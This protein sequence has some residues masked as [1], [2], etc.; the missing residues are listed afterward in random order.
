MGPT[1]HRIAPG[2]NVARMSVAAALAHLGRIDQA[3]AA[4]VELRRLQ[5]NATM[6]RIKLASFA[7]DCMY[8]LCFDGFKAGLPETQQAHFRDHASVQAKFDFRF[9]VQLEPNESRTFCRRRSGGNRMR[10][11][12]RF[13]WTPHQYHARHPH[14]CFV[15]Q[16][17][18]I[19]GSAHTH[20]ETGARTC[21]PLCFTRYE[22]WWLRK[23]PHVESPASSPLNTAPR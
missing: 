19:K 20:E 11:H 9:A 10:S 23:R 18:L 16:R 6:E 12:G 4:I 14:Q 3:R 5:P 13:S 2:A 15:C 7:R 21:R 1:C 17:T 22:R 8:D